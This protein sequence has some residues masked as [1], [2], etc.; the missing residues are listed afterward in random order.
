MVTSRIIGG[1]G[2]Q[3]FQYAAGKA[4][5]DF[6]KVEFRI[7]VAAFENYKV[8]DYDLKYFN[9][10]A[11]EADRVT[12]KDLS[13]PESN[14]TVLNRY[15]FWKNYKKI[16]A[17][18]EPFPFF[19]RRFFKLPK[20][21]YLNGYFQSEK[22][23][24]SIDAAIRQEFSLKEES[25]CLKKFKSEVRNINAVSVH[26]RRGNYAENPGIRKI[27]GLPDSSYYLEAMDKIAA[28]VDKPEFYIFSN[29]SAW[30]RENLKFKYPVNFASDFG[31]KN[32]EEMVAMSLCK[33]NITGNS[34]FSWWSAWLNSNPDKIV[35]TPA[36]WFKWRKIQNRDL[37]PASWVK[38]PVTLC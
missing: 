19:D 35:I 31:L 34:T 14:Y 38:L 4:L 6:H 18:T 2:N 13:A 24:S 7:D 37:L 30:V 15:I 20:E 17:Y 32:H 9:I 8:H 16:T 1:L 27:F 28:K 25:D 33:H 11:R 36:R 26:F 5:A 12:P 3:M 21:V 23:F 29:D 22:Y 10:S